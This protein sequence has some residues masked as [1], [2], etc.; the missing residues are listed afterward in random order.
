MLAPS[1]SKS[2]P[3]IGSLLAAF[4]DRMRSRK[5]R[6]SL[7]ECD[8]YEVER[9][10]HEFG[11]SPRELSLM[12]KFGPGAAD[13]LPRRMAAMGLDPAVVDQCEP[14]TMRDLQRL[15]SACKS[16][17]ICQRDLRGDHNSGWV[18]YCPNA[19]TLFALQQSTVR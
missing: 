19:G 7:D 18:R 10:A 16:K 13:L 6:L 4:C 5:F 3:F 2:L 14:A 12:S 17:K 11:L 1:P 15:C 9:M 8:S